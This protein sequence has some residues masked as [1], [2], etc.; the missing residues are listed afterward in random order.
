EVD[1][2]NRDADW[3]RKMLTLEMKMNDQ[4]LLGWREGH[5]KGRSEG[6]R[7]GRSEGLREGRLETKRE[8]ALK[9]LQENCDPTFIS[10]ITDLSVD[11]ILALGDKDFSE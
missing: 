7:E 5:S 9:M 2:A 3:R 4:R 6:L 1:I 8:D 10:K 11:E